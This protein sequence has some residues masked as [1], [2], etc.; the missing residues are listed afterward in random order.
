MNLFAGLELFG[1][2]FGLLLL[3]CPVVLIAV[4]FVAAV[5]GGKVFRER[6]LGMEQH[7]REALG[8]F[9]ADPGNT[10]LRR[11]ALDAGRKYSQYARKMGTDPYFDEAA[12]MNDLNA[13]APSASAAMEPVAE[14]KQTIADQL[15]TLDDLWNQG[16]ITEDEY[17]TRRT[18]ILEDV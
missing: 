9:R 8:R 2:V 7:Y 1:I 11:A 17:H 12:I 3:A 4:V 18:A 10:E 16:L 14:P 6:S 15:K 13:T 5:R